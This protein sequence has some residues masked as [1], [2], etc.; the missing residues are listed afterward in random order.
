MSEEHKEATRR[1]IEIMQ[2]YVDGKPIECRIPPSGEFF[3]SHSSPCWAWDVHDYRIA[4]I[5]DS[6]DWSHVAPE[7]K[8]M[9]RDRSGSVYLYSKKP[10]IKGSCWDAMGDYLLAENFASFKQGTVDWENSLVIRPE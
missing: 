2:A 3:I 8:Y 1:K 5:P 7:W 9:A 6:I 4:T 10:D